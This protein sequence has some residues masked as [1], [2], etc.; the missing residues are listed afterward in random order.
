MKKLLLLAAAL[1]SLSVQ[2]RELTFYMGETAIKPGET[3][4]F[5]GATLDKAGTGFDVVMAPELYLHS[6]I[7]TSNVTVKAECTSGQSIQ[8]C[9]GGNCMSGTTVTKTG[10]RIASDQ[11]LPL[12]FEYMDYVA[13]E[14]DVPEVVTSFTAVDP[15]YPDTQ[16]SMV[17]TMKHSAG[18]GSV[19]VSVSEVTVTKGALKYKVDAPSVLSLVDIT[20][21]TVLRREIADEGSVDITSLPGGLYIYRL[22]GAATRSGKFQ[23]R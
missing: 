18:V 13:S 2:A 10:V 21:R 20:G 1:L 14:K 16:I 4:V 23:I 15:K 12:E 22:T 8:M 11:K 5:T 19:S 3:V 9:A 7:V 17:V 6:D